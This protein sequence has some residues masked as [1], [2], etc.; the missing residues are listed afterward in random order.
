M[1]EPIPDFWPNDIG[2]T[3]MVTPL[4]ILKEEASYLGP[5]TNQLVKAEVLTTPQPDGRFVHSFII[6]VPGLSNY[7]YQLFNLIH[8]ITLYPAQLVWRG[9]GTNIATQ[10]DLT[11]K[12]REMIG[13]PE[14][15]QIVAALLAQVSGQPNA[16]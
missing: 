15:K 3:D 12:L 1:P 14:T 8:P 7:R 6:T 16:G 5:K 2:Q 10:D 13:A 4:S 11:A 9:V